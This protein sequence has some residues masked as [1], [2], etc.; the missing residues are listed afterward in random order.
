MTK[1]G[2]GI[3]GKRFLGLLSTALA[4]GVLSSAPTLSGNFASAEARPESRDA[5]MSAV[6]APERTLSDKSTAARIEALA[7]SARPEPRAGGLTVASRGAPARLSRSVLDALP[8]AK[9]DEQWRCLATA[10]YFESRGEPLMG[11][12]AVAEVILNRVDD[13]RFPN[14]VCAVTTQ[15][16]GS[17]GRACQFSYA[18]D[19]RSDVMAA[20]VARERSE[21][22]AALML[23]GRER[24]VTSGATHFHATYV[25]PR[26]SRR[27]TRTAA[28]GAH[29][30]FRN[31]TRVSRR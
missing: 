8:S 30:F 26:W 21:K 6:V 29:L 17:A 12:I 2:D 14:S 16:V 5:R 3:R 25:N 15:G 4:I 1:I 23:A 27:M 22:L 13:R 7:S 20:G 28:V 31:G 11:Q 9:G 10:I 19:G 24:V 18:C